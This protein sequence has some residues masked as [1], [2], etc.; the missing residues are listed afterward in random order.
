VAFLPAAHVLQEGHVVAVALT[1]VLYVPAAQSEQTP[2]SCVV[3]QAEA[4]FLPAAHVLQ[5]QTQ[6]VLEQSTLQP[7]VQNL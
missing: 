4:A 7:E 2:V 6:V 3:V 1:P 5:L